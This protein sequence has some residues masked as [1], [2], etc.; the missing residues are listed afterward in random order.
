VALPLLLTKLLIHLGVA[1]HLPV[2]QKRTNGGGEFL[3]YYSNR[4]LTSPLEQLP[5]AAEFLQQHGPDVLDL[6]LG[7]PRCDVA[8]S[9]STKLPADRRGWP[10]VE[11]LPEL[12]GA[13]AAK[14]L[15][16]ND[17]AVNPDNEVLITAGVVGAAQ[18]VL[19]AFVNP[20]DAVVLFD[21]SSP[22]YPL[23]V[24]TRGAR[25]RWLTTWSDDGR[26]RFR[27]DHLARALRHARLLILA[28]PGN[29]TGGVVAVEDLEQIAWWANRLDV[30]VLSDEVFER[31]HHDTE[32]VS[33]ATLPRAR[34]RTLTTGSVSK[35]HG[36]ASA[37][38]GWLLGHRHLLLPCL[39]TA[40]LRTP[41]VPT[42]CQQVAL[43]ALQSDPA[44][45]E[46]VRDELASRRRYV[47]ERLRNL[48]V[49][50]PWP[51]GAFF[52]WVPVWQL[53]L[54][55]R[56]FADALLRE[57]NV[58]V[59]P[60]D[61]FGPSGAGYIRLSYATEE[62]RLQEALNRLAAFVQSLRSGKPAA[63]ARNAA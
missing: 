10:P 29:P 31:F 30:L 52:F 35:G 54:S 14:L 13:V 28:S 38:V 62:G 18:T 39:A 27:L 19:D 56:D 15:A 24:R 49:N 1:R 53:G 11:G 37:R 5:V 57:Q 33:I 63:V 58:L 2:V 32:P 25:V 9:T 26:T 41:F 55:G 8:P 36:L 40:A 34:E 59:T 43:T 47:Y 4:L 50:P 46:E 23:L 17:V 16:D 48:E 21:P 42:L 3:R 20:G 6:A 44:P 7:T 12:R 60:G 22:L 45:F 51:A 61:L